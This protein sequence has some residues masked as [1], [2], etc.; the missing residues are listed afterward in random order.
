MLRANELA[1]AVGAH[2]PHHPPHPRHRLRQIPPHELG[3]HTH[4]AVPEPREVP[5]PTRIRGAPLGVI[6]PVHFHH[7]LDRGREKVGHVFPDRHLPAEGR[8]QLPAAQLLPQSF[9][10]APNMVPPH[11]WRSA[12]APRR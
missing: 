12:R 11:A 4:H 6:P 10:G 3:L 1:G 7:D 8:A 2:S 9:F 5:V